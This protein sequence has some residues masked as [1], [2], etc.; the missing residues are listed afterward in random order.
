LPLS[1]P[2][3]LHECLENPGSAIRII[4]GDLMAVPDTKEERGCRFPF[5][6]RTCR[7]PE[8]ASISKSLHRGEVTYPYELIKT[9]PM[10]L[11]ILASL[12]SADFLNLSRVNSP[13]LAAKGLFLIGAFDTP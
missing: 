9:L 11:I 13:Q 8:N 6:S 1:R 5:I 4:A 2:P 12:R 3:R 7:L 10:T